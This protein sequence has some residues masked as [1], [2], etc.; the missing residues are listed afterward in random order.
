MESN[1]RLRFTNQ[2]KG[3]AQVIEDLGIPRHYS[4]YRQGCPSLPVVPLRSTSIRLVPV[5]NTRLTPAPHVAELFWR[6]LVAVQSNSHLGPDYGGQVTPLVQPS[7]QWARPG[8][9]KAPTVPT[10][11]HVCGI[12]LEGSIRRV[13]ALGLPRR[14]L[15]E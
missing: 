15:V 14:A 11:E 4:G 1:Y 10:K 2:W 6:S 5:P 8:A 9:R 7:L 13:G 12:D 3:D